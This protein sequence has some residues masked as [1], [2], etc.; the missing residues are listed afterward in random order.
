MDQDDVD[1]RVVR[2]ILRYLAEHPRAADTTDGIQRWWLRGEV[3]D[4]TH[5]SIVTVIDHLVRSGYLERH[6]LPSGGAVYRAAA[7][8]GPRKDSRRTGLERWRLLWASLGAPQANDDLYAALRT[9][10]AERHRHY[11]TL[12]HIEECFAHLDDLRR[13]AE[14]PAEV[15]VALWFH[16]A[17]YQPK[18]KDNE[19]RSAKWAKTSLTAVGIDE[20]VGQ[21][22]ADLILATRHAALPKTMDAKVL[23]D[24]DLSILGVDAARFEEYE[25]QVRKEYQ[26]L[27]SPMYRRERSKVLKKLLDRPQIFSTERMFRE[28]ESRARENLNRSLARLGR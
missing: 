23:V 18:R 24:V 11:H 27:P 7:G 28:L 25:A 22:V 10:Y 15:E 8:S 16:D 14:H 5:E 12:R 13:L 19:Q 1:P 9:R 21:R 20:M 17:I 6:A 26:W 3:Q 2:A 4:A